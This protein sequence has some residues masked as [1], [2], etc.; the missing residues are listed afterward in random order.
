MTVEESP[1]NRGGRRAGAGRKRIPI[2]PAQVEQL[3]ALGCPIGEIADFLGVELRTL[4]NRMKTREFRE[5]VK[6]GRV[7]YKVIIRRGQMDLI[8]RRDSRTINHLGRTILKQRISE[9]KEKP[10]E[11]NK[12]LSVEAFDELLAIADRKQYLAITALSY[13]E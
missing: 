8:E 2:N 5:A 6:R 1:P 4:Q 3:R 9:S 10:L 13:A 12:E 11:T 7:R